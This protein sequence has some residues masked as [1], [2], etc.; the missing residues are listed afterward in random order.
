MTVT[1]FMAILNSSIDEI[2]EAVMLASVGR[3][4]VTSEYVEVVTTLIYRDRKGGRFFGLLENTEF[5]TALS[6][7]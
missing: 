2:Y 1:Q 3:Y 4:N 5:M 7:L 6:H